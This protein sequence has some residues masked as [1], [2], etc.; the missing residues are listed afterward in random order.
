MTRR[1]LPFALV[2]VLVVVATSVMV[3]TRD[4]ATP[5]PPPPPAAEPTGLTMLVVN[6]EAG[7][8]AAVIGSTG[9]GEPGAVVLPLE[10]SLTVP[11][12]GEATV[13]EALQLNRRQAA[14]AAANLLGVWIDHHAQIGHLRLAELVDRAGGVE[15]GGV[16]RSGAEVDAM[17]AEPGTDR[18]AA[19]QIALQGIL[20][21]GVQWT[22]EDLFE[23]D[24]P[25]AV[26]ETLNGAAGARVTRLPNEEVASGLFQSSPEIV[27]ATLVQTFGGPAEYAV[28]VIVLNGNGVP[29]IGQGVAQQILPGGF[30]VAVSENAST[31]DH[32]ETLVVVGS[33]NDV[34]L[35][36]RV[37]DLLGVGSVSVS[38]GSGIA[39]V[40]VVVGKDFIV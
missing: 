33:S 7:P 15:I 4:R 20:S 10:T 17:L 19:L 26:V 38:V 2:G 40:T 8:L 16:V 1:L 35:A 32:E 31:F 13:A 18:S 37:R 21:S 5:P 11:G 34:D 28:P 14:T 6:G 12:Q 27:T 23:A 39:P 36:E 3:A 25:A 29:G 30:R 22:E 9:F 24:D